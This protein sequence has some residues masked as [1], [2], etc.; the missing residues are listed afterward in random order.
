[1]PTHAQVLHETRGVYYGVVP[2]AATVDRG[3]AG[4]EVWVVSRPHN[5]RP[6][7]S[8]EALLRIDTKT[9]QLIEACSPFSPPFSPFALHSPASSHQ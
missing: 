1:M 2:G 5:W 6:A 4:S 8:K 7:T 3:S 9:G